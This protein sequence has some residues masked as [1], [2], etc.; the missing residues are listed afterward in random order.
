M[1]VCRFDEFDDLPHIFLDAEAADDGEALSNKKA[2]RSDEVRRPD[3]FWVLLFALNEGSGWRE[4]WMFSRCIDVKVGF[5]GA[6]VLYRA[7]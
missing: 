5:Y 6:R 1:F 2:R 3:M 7:M 4:W